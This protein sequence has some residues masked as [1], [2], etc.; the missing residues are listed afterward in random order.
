MTPGADTQVG[1]LSTLTGL[2]H[3]RLHGRHQII[4]NAAELLNIETV[5]EA[6]EDE[7][8]G[9]IIKT[10]LFEEIIPTLDFCLNEEDCFHFLASLRWCILLLMNSSAIL[11]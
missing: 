10:A 1:N 5:R 2:D 3:S 6:V 4:A 11:N 8:V 7:V 9:D